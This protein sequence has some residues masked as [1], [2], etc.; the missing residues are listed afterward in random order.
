MVF[1][2]ESWF[3]RGVQSAAFYYLSCTPCVDAKYRQKRKQEAVSTSEKHTVVT[4]QPG[5]IQQPRAF[6]TNEAWAE[7]ILR[8]PG[9]PP[10]YKGQNDILLRKL[11]R[12]NMNAELTARERD[13]QPTDHSLVDWPQDVVL[14]TPIREKCVL[15]PKDVVILT[16]PKKRTSLADV[17]AGA[18]KTTK[19]NIEKRLSDS[20]PRNER[21]S[22]TIENLKDTLKSTLH[23]DKW[24]L[25]RYEREDEDLHV[26]ELVKDKR[27]VR[28]TLSSWTT[29]RST[30]ISDS[31]YSNRP[32]ANR[33]AGELGGNSQADW[34]R[35][36]YKEKSQPSS[37]ILA[38]PHLSREE[39]TSYFEQGS[40]G[41]GSGSSGL[42]MANRMRTILQPRQNVIQ[43][44]WQRPKNPEINELHP[45][46]VSNLP[47]T[48]EEAAWMLLPPPKAAVMEGKLP[49]NTDAGNMRYPMCRVET[50][51]QRVIDY[52]ILLKE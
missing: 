32:S 9:P 31:E 26:K 30:G 29:I 52:T 8:G 6:E 11:K 14:P 50:P 12:S 5:V 27:S 41:I 36:E 33:M 22:S 38:N 19:S 21:K 20:R 37:F 4:Q 7:E 1:F 39:A 44:D 24:N 43:Y 35:L 17:V 42:A 51:A 46:V 16:P 45:P 25:K 28:G 15:A 48:R 3:L 18:S 40:S 49:P 13:Q 34:E 2:C 10:K 23:S 47:N